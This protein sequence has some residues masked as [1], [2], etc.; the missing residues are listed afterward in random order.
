MK[1]RSPL[2]ASMGDETGPSGPLSLSDLPEICEK[3]LRNFVVVND[4]CI[5][6]YVENEPDTD[7]VLR[8]R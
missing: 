2:V 6:C 4:V 7:L 1:L 3:C 5:G 8:D